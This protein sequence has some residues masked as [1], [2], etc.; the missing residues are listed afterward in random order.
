[1]SGITKMKQTYGLSG[2]KV[3]TSPP[4]LLELD[5]ARSRKA[6]GLFSFRR[7][8]TKVRVTRYCQFIGLREKR[9]AGFD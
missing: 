9:A 5:F 8:S 2:A 3:S 1:M 4:T 7:C 6:C